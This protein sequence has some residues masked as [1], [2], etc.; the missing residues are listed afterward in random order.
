LTAYSFQRQFIDP[1]SS[2]S[3]L[4]T[5]RAVGKRRHAKVGGQ[6]Q[7]YFGMRTA[8]CR[9]IIEDKPCVRFDRI[10]LLLYSHVP[11]VLIGEEGR[12]VHLSERGD[13]DRFAVLD[14]FENWAALDDFWRTWHPDHRFFDGVM[15]G[16][17]PGFW[18]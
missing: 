13:L 12:P 8:H 16:W 15:V 7:L 1:I 10:R 5:I 3:K 6:L 17:G 2:G 14:G 9:K 4:Q 18:K 11:E